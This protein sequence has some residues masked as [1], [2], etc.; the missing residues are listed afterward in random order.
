[1]GENKRPDRLSKKEGSMFTFVFSHKL[2]T[3]LIVLLLVLSILTQ[4]ATGILFQHMIKEADNMPT[5][6]NKLLK[7]C[8]TKYI[9]CFKLN[10]KM[11]NTSVF[12]DKFIL[13][14]RF[15]GIS[16]SKL[17]HLSGQL[18]MLSVVVTGVAICLSL[19]AGDT[20][21]EIIPYYLY[22]ILGLYL[23]FSVSGI[24]DLPGKTT[25]L[26]TNL[27]DYLENHLMPRLEI[28]KEASRE[29]ENKLREI[30]TDMIAE[31]GRATEDAGEEPADTSL[32]PSPVTPPAASRTIPMDELEDLL[33]E[34]FA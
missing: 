30:N 12:V 5:T 7:K 18:M 33:K 17:T 16:F 14:I 20:L 3:I 22:S 11:L 31:R 15:W 8:K 24:V 32:T 28:E 25:Q 19:A 23:Y 6:K 1:M 26:K 4:L 29:S 9:N 27:V 2:F 21:F 34:L 13:K 10:G